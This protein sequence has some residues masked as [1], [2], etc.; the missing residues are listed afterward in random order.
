[1]DLGLPRDGKSYTHLADTRLAGSAGK[2]CSDHFCALPSHTLLSYV[3]AAIVQRGV[4]V[5]VVGMFLR[6]VGC[7][8]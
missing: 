2:D 8:V 3:D 5:G 1:M 4:V 7:Y 6:P